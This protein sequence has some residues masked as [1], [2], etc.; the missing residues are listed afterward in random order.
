[1]KF[2]LKHLPIQQ[3]IWP[4]YSISITNRHVFI[5]HDNQPD[6][7]ELYPTRRHNKQH[8]FLFLNFFPSILP[9][10]STRHFSTIRSSLQPTE[11]THGDPFASKSAKTT[12]LFYSYNFLDTSL[13][14]RKYQSD[15]LSDKKIH[16]ITSDHIRDTFILPNV[17]Q[18][19]QPSHIKSSIP[20][21]KTSYIIS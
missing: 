2:P 1:M 10:A 8:Y 5:N 13:L 17:Q 19:M 20:C 3:N 11:I 4:S 21:F 14:P 12:I 15:F 9:N 18:N 7:Q 16:T 6:I